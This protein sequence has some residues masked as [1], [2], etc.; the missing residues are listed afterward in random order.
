MSMTLIDLLHRKATMPFP[1]IVCLVGSTRFVQAYQDANLRETLSGR[2]VLT[3]GC[4][5]KSDHDLQL[6]PIDKT[7]LDILHLCKIE[8]ADEVLVLN[9]DGYI[10]ESTRRE[11][12][13]ARLLGKTL[14]WLEPEVTA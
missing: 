12:E 14:R 4:D 9:V 5:T 10:G 13:Y 7:R 6:G 3:I 1:T 2:I 11:I 8:R